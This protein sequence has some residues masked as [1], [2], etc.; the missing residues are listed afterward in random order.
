[1]RARHLTRTAL[2]AV[3]LLVGAAARPVAA[4]PATY[5]F[6]WT[7]Q[8]ATLAGVTLPAQTAFTLRAFGDP[9]SAVSTG[10]RI[11]LAGLSAE[12]EIGGLGRL[13][14]AHPIDVEVAPR[15]ESSPFTPIDAGTLFFIQRI[16]ST[17]PFLGWVH[18]R[19]FF[20]YDLRTSRSIVAAT[21]WCG[22][23][24]KAP[25]CAWM[26]FS[27][28]LATDRG[29]LLFDVG[30][31]TRFPSAGAI[32]ASSAVPE[33]GTA[34]LLAPPLLGVLYGVARRRDVRDAA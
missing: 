4:Q 34:L 2:P 23:Q 28:R 30:L 24:A 15:D 14:V 1:M 25:P 12:L 7:S 11:T 26:N 27:G 21:D 8:S 13:A 20:D 6:D 3:F 29:E 9:S 31:P 17:E 16:G 18:A 22:A 33:P 19:E 32:V 10:G 5:V